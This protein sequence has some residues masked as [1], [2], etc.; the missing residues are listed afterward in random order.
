MFTLPAAH[1]ASAI[2]VSA[3]TPRLRSPGATVTSC[4]FSV[5]ARTVTISG[6]SSSGATGGRF[7]LVSSVANRI[8]VPP[9]RGPTSANALAEKPWRATRPVSAFTVDGVPAAPDPKMCGLC[10][11]RHRKANRIRHEKAVKSSFK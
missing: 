3:A 2:F 5:A 4:E 1:R 9:G 6:Q 8:S 11:D 10:L 7:G